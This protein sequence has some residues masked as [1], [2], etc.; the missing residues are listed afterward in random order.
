MGL[1]E[2]HIFPRL[3]DLATRQFEEARRDI[4]GG[5]GGRVLE[6]GVG[7]GNNLPYY[8]ALADEVVA[9]EISPGMLRRARVRADSL[10]C[11]HPTGPLIDIRMGDVTHLELGDGTFDTVVSFLVFCSLPDPARAAGELYRVLKPGGKLLVFEHVVAETAR[12]RAWQNRLNPIW[13]FFAC[14]CNLNRD[15][16]GILETAGFDCSEVRSLREEGSGSVGLPIVHG[17]ASKPLLAA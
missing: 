5:A 15:T 16:R 12:W 11:E 1:Y 9:I 4:I 7:T 8:S 10:R 17:V 2:Q 6:I 3:C 14:G 13:S